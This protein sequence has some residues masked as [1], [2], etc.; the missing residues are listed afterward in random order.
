MLSQAF[1]DEASRPPNLASVFNDAKHPAWGSVF[2]AI[3]S[4]ELNRFRMEKLSTDQPEG[5]IH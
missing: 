1:Q 3:E 4:D 5:L 2:S